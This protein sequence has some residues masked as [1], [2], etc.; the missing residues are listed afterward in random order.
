MKGR[1]KWFDSKKGY[2]FITGEDGTDVFV[3]FS[4]VD[5]DGYKKLDEDQE[6]EFEVVQ[7][8]KGPQASKVRPL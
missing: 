6:V 2:G 1:V 5:M 3:H 7:G 8:Q 4:A